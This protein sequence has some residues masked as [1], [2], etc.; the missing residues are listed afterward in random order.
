[1]Y[2]MPSTPFTCCSMGAATVSATTSALAPG[3]LAD[4]SMVG[5]AISGYCATGSVTSVTR[6]A[7]VTMIDST[8]AK[9]GR[10]MKKRET[11][12]NPR[13]QLSGEPP[14]VRPR[15]RNNASGE[16]LT[17]AGARGAT[18]RPLSPRLCGGRGAG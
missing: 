9:I 1:M 15:V 3:K 18:Q 11:T 13:L 5:G 16:A 12:K 2:I 7:S 8:D 6:P 10:L 14:A 4:T 17:D